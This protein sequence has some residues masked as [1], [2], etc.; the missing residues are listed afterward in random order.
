MTKILEGGWRLGAALVLLGLVAGHATAQDGAAIIQQQCVACHSIGEG[1]RV[2]P[3]LAGVTERR[4]V[5][6]LRR[7][8][9]EPDALIAEGDPTVTRLVERYNRI[10]MPNLGLQEAQ[11]DAIIA[12]LQ[13]LD[14][15][16]A[17]AP[18]APAVVYETPELMP[19]QSRIWHMFLL[20]SA[21]IALVFATVAFSTRKPAAVNT[22]RAYRVRRVLFLAALV[23]VIGIL[24]TTMP[25]APYAAQLGKDQQADRIVYVTA[26]QFEFVFTDEP[27]TRSEDL[28][29]LQRL[30]RLQVDPGEWVEFRVT[31]LDVNHGFGL[32]GP[33]RQI[34]AQT[35]AMP[36]YVNRLQVQFEQPGDYM[37]L[38]LEYC[39]AGHH[40]MR[41]GLTVRQA[42]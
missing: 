3:D 37:V 10:V 8:I 35:Q 22:E 5:A 16:G 19:P 21:V 38:C 25:D 30:S 7:M 4:D 1:D 14:A 24:A 11:A 2:G 32:Y 31:S 34:I 20:I 40:R 39:A 27:V 13:S 12:H 36:G 9:V 33:Q 17:A 26:R 42:R 6:W 18:T 28:G 23:A 41:S 15:A 29:R